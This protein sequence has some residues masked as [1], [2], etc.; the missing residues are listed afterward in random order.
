MN[1]IILV[2]LVEESNEMPW[3]MA[4]ENGWGYSYNNLNFEF[5]N[6][7][8]YKSCKSIVLL[9]YEVIWFCTNTEEPPSK[10]KI[11][12]LTDSERVPWGKDEKFRLG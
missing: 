10:P 2:T 8:R 12:F 5:L 9:I 11:P 7:K 6:L 4:N 3:V 1:W